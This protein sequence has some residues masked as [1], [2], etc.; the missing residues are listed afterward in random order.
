VHVCVQHRP[1]RIS[2]YTVEKR[3]EFNFKHR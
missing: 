1:P 3:T 2:E